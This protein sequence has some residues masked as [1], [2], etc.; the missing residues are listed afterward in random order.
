MKLTGSHEIVSL[1]AFLGLASLAVLPTA[2]EKGLWFWALSLTFYL[3][4]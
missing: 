2:L 4:C 3:T 1:P